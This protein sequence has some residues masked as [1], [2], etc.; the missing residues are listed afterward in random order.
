MQVSFRVRTRIEYLGNIAH[1]IKKNRQVVERP[2]RQDTT[3]YDA[4]IPRVEGRPRRQVV[5]HEL[6]G[7][8]SGTNNQRATGGAKTRGS[9]AATSAKTEVSG[10][11][12]FC[13]D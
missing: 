12:L 13:A 7:E 8:Y 1:I 9:L 10:G 6:P 11:V 4:T 3:T 5:R 2:G